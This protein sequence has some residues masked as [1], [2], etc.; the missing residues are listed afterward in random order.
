MKS[1]LF[2]NT[3]PTEILFNFL[4]KTCV[5][6]NN[7]YLFDK[8]AHKKGMFNNES[9]LFVNMCK[10]YYHLSKQHYAEKPITSNSL[11]TIIRQIC[12]YNKITYTSKMKYD[13]SNYEIIYYIYTTV[14]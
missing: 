14:F 7:C 9:L 10:P 4:N 13:K 1:Q 11:V 2:K 6:S 5:K 3:V 12:K 8:A